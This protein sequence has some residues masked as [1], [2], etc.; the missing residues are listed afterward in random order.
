M[1][2]LSAKFKSPS[3]ASRHYYEAQEKLDTDNECSSTSEM[4]ILR[5]T[6]VPAGDLS[7]VLEVC[8][9]TLDSLQ[10][11]QQLSILSH[12]VKNEE[13]LELLELAIYSFVIATN[14]CGE[15]K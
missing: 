6:V 8:R 7:M 12:T 9:Q 2:K 14:S 3:D 1:I 10:P 4:Q 5:P 15:F 13:F 11:S